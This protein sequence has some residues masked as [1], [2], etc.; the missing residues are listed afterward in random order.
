MHRRG[1][2]CLLEVTGTNSL[3]YRPQAASLH[4]AA[5]SPSQKQGSKSP[6][7]SAE[8]KGSKASSSSSQRYSLKPSNDAS[9]PK[10]S[11]YS[12]KTKKT[13]RQEWQPEKYSRHHETPSKKN[14]KPDTLSKL[15]TDI[16][17]AAVNNIGK[18]DWT[19]K[20]QEERL[21][22]LAV[23][24]V[25]SIE[26]EKFLAQETDAGA[27]EIEEDQS[28]SDLIQPGMFVELRRCA[29]AYAVAEASYNIENT[30]TTKPCM[31]S[32]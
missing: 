19:S 14:V 26:V 13:H 16:I 8:R 3:A 17:H 9:R 27:S 29:H 12:H 30:G 4:S 21:R 6:A 15:T 10:S 32:S 22:K 23:P 25:Q 20:D 28:T 18:A 7:V 24:L 31:P 1:L 2:Q 5:P 11:S